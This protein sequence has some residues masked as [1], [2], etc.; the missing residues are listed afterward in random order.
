MKSIEAKDQ[1]KL[2][3]ARA[4]QLAM[5]GMMYRFF[6]SGITA[7][8]LCLAVAFLVYTL[9]SGFLS[10]NSQFAAARE[11]RA[12]RELGGV[13]NR[14]MTP[15]QVPEI[16]DNFAK[17]KD[18]RL[19][20][21]KL[22]GE[23]SD[24]DVETAVSTAS[25]VYEVEKHFNQALEEHQA[26]LGVNVD[27][28]TLMRDLQ[29]PVQ[30]DLFKERI[31]GLPVDYPL[32]G[33]DD[34]NLL[35]NEQWPELMDIASRIR[36]GH[37][38]AVTQIDEAYPEQNVRDILITPPDDLAETLQKAGYETEA[39]D[40]ERL[41]EFAARSQARE[42]LET[43]L[44]K[45]EVQV[46]LMERIG[47]GAEDLSTNTVFKWLIGEPENA[48]WLSKLLEKAGNRI[49][50]DR[51][52]A[53]A[54]YFERTERL[55]AAAG[56]EPPDEASGILSL[57]G[58]LFWLILLAF[59]VCVVGVANAML[60]SVT[61]RFT[62]IATMKCLGA[63]DGFVMMMFVFEASVQGLVGGVLGAVLGVALAFFRGFIE[64]GTLLNV[65][66]E[67]VGQISLATLVSMLVG[68]IL[69][70]IAAL[71]PSLLAARLA[72]M[73]AMRVE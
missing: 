73:E 61:E 38:E 49:S 27:I 37:R 28:I 6:R 59:V 42:Q 68:I 47:V 22:W 56:S 19:V 8:I 23:L 41:S 9:V 21:Y 69:A 29:Q 51:L 62:E 13:I 71:G 12:E 55:Q 45:R 63:L 36:A 4:L 64:F 72:P 53:M 17:E 1:I 48:Q 52:L 3:P 10:H 11:L 39:L 20:E 58:R 32:G 34:F 50:P 46:P 15:D 24:K 7:A 57:E 35:V 30:Y 67:M 44:I 33:N 43:M 65:T 40:F 31:D 16:V 66:S 54:D 70:A 60:M 26:I 14:L 25:R 18:H 2:G 5:S